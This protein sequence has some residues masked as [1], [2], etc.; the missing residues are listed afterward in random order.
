MPKQ[1]SFGFFVLALLLSL[2]SRVW[3][4]ELRDAPFWAILQSLNTLIP[5]DS[6]QASLGVIFVEL[7]VPVFSWLPW[8]SE[9]ERHSVLW[10]RVEGQMNPYGGLF[11]STLDSERKPFYFPVDPDIS[12]H[13]S[14]INEE[15][16]SVEVIEEVK[17]FI[18]SFCKP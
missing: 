17:N 4:G 16:K 1:I 10:F 13:C 15:V 6:D 18:L 5:K 14:D 12:L 3:S 9:Q 2:S 7:E 8:P 11:L